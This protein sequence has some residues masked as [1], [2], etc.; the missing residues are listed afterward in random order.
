MANPARDQSQNQN[1]LQQVRELASAKKALRELKD[2]NIELKKVATENR[3]CLAAI[4]ETLMGLSNSILDKDF[5]AIRAFLQDVGELAPSIKKHE[6]F[7]Q[8]N[9]AEEQAT[10]NTPAVSE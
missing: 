1:N 10:V 6:N 2:Q 9:T 3:G 8:D 4:T 7:P 5:G